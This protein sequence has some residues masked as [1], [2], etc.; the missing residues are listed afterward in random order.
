MEDEHKRSCAR[1]VAEQHARNPDGQTRVK[2]IKDQSAQ[3][4][5]AYTHPDAFLDV[6]LRCVLG[7]SSSLPFRFVLFS[8]VRCVLFSY[9]L[10]SLP[11]LPSASTCYLERPVQALHS[12]QVHA[13]SSAWYSICASARALK[14]KHVCYIQ[15]SFFRR[16]TTKRR[17]GSRLAVGGTPRPLSRETR[18]RNRRPNNIL[19]INKYYLNRRIRDIERRRDPD[20]SWKCFSI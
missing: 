7:S 10:G 14:I 1:E 15:P 5:R 6:F 12:L 20:P 3:A 2:S 9:V 16:K 17:H 8:Y 18:Q 4:W 11:P 13:P 19:I